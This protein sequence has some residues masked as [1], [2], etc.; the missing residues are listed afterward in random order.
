MSFAQPTK[1]ASTGTEPV[2]DLYSPAAENFCPSGEARRNLT[3][4][5]L[6]VG[7]PASTVKAIRYAPGWSTVNVPGFLDVGSG[8]EASEPKGLYAIDHA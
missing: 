8:N 2:S 1:L 4:W 5:K 3:V 7:K 6:S